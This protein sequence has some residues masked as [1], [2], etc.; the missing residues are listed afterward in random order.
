MPPE[1]L[2]LTWREPADLGSMCLPSQIDLIK[3]RGH[4]APAVPIKR[5][6]EIFKASPML[7]PRAVQEAAT[8]SLATIAEAEQPIVIEDDDDAP[9]TCSKGTSGASFQHF[10]LS[11]G[12]TRIGVVASSFASDNLGT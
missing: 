12:T 9:R 10:G 2:C 1:A 7:R 3:P 8:S 11:N 5:V 6:G 4:D